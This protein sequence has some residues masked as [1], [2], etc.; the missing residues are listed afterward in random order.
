MAL[1]HHTCPATEVYICVYTSSSL[2]PGLRDRIPTHGSSCLK[3]SCW[4]H[5]LLGLIG[6][7][8]DVHCEYSHVLN[9]S[10]RKREKCKKWKELSPLCHLL[11]FSLTSSQKL[12]LSRV[13]RPPSLSCK[14][15]SGRCL[16]SCCL[17]I[18]HI[19][20]RLCA[21]C[22]PVTHLVRCFGLQ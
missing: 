20:I 2:N 9:L 14:C 4:Q 10:E 21:L 16:L 22:N 17:I 13:S 5:I 8:S 12:A 1:F 7:V 18:D 11:S 3:T 6:E 15:R 19:L